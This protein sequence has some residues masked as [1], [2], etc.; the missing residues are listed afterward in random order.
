MPRPKKEKPNRSDNRY[1]IKITLGKSLDGKQKQKS[2]YSTISKADAKLK[3]ENWKIEQKASEMAGVA[4][5]DKTITFEKWAYIWLT[6]YKK[7]SV[8]GNTFEESYKRILDNH[9]IPYFGKYRLYD[10]KAIDV[11]IFFNLKSNS[12]SQATLDKMRISLNS[13]FETAI[14]NDLCYKNP[15]KNVKAISKKKTAEKRTYSISERDKLL[16]ISKNYKNGI[17]LYLMLE[18]GLR[19][20]EVCALKREDFDTKKETVHIERASVCINGK[21]FISNPKSKTSNRI[22][23]ISKNLNNIVKDIKTQ[24]FLFLDSKGKNYTARTFPHGVYD[25]LFADIINDHPEIKKLNM[26]ELRH[27]CGTLLYDRTKD[28]FAVSRFMGHSSV[29]ITESTYIHDDVE[30]LRSHLM[31]E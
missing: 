3:A 23:P 21:P 16:E 7:G 30:M 1:E 9:L 22:L 11:T 17:V 2:F 10:I 18:L 24:G 8:K 27:T 13:I 12:Y 31:I 4:F 19:C 29:K 6:K 15:V 28:V 14:D 25:H 20:S 26:H 5:V